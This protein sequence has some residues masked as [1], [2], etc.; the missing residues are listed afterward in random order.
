MGI[1][2]D[3]IE[4]IVDAARRAG[5]SAL[6]ETE[7]IELLSVLGIK[8]PPHFFV[9]APDDVRSSD[10]D[11]LA[12]ERVVVKVISGTILHKTELGGV[13]VTAKEQAAVRR[14]IGD[15]RDRLS[16][17]QLEGFTVHQFVA[18]DPSL[19][20]ELLLG[21]RWTEDFG[22][23]VVFGGGGIH[24]ELLARHFKPGRNIAVL[25]ALV[26]PSFGISAVLSRTAVA[27]LVSWRLRGREPR[28]PLQRL[29]EACQKVGE[30]AASFS[31]GA[32]TD[33]EINPL[34][35]ADGELTALDVLAKLAPAR[36]RAQRPP[37]PLEKI[38]N[39]LE[40]RSIAVVG[41]SGTNKNAGRV[42]LENSL[43]EGFDRDNLFVVKP[44]CGEIE[45]CRCFP[46]IR[47]LPGKIDLVVLAVGA[48][49]IPDLVGQIVAHEKAESVIVIP[50]GLEEKS[51]SGATVS[52]L[53]E[54]I[55]D[56][57]RLPWRGPVINGGNSLGIRSRPGRY[58]TM[59]I[60]KHKLGD[61]RHGDGSVAF[62]SQ[63]GAFAIAKGSTLSSVDLRYTISIGNQ[64]DLTIGDY[65]E[66]L[67]TDRAID[68]FAVYVEGFK[69]LDGVRFL[70]AA[71]KI[72]SS[73]R[74]V[75]LYA[76]GR[77]EAGARA[78]ASHTASVAGNYAVTRDLSLG[79]GVVVAETLADFEDLVMLFHAVR[80]RELRGLRL[81][82]VSNA[83]FE[84][85][86]VADNLGAFRLEPFSPRTVAAILDIF[87][88]AGVDRIVDV[89][90]PL[91]LTPMVND[92]GYE[93]V[94]RTVMDDDE[95]DVGLVGCVPLSPALNTLTPG[96]GHKEDLGSDDS[97]V[98]R[99]IRLNRE[100]QK[101]WIAVVDGG[102]L[103]SAMRQQ[104]TE[105]GVATF[106]TADRA[107]Q[108]LTIFY[109][110]SL[111]KPPGI[112]A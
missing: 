70:E 110:T 108:I 8:T 89:H 102:S 68:I 32:F 105:N 92:A 52:K 17:R 79:A 39:L 98:R 63:S 91:D 64:M 29:I 16:D 57:R 104:L 36:D 3:R 46:D 85:V 66:Y 38:R 14:A 31:P 49:Q 93:A 71:K 55:A 95:V 65:L 50:G 4:Q 44:E 109:E 81:G 26:P 58:D 13:V 10:L 22:P 80:G 12:G 53:S 86:A 106:R 7:G 77:S 43:R 9:R 1:A 2:R 42:I 34:V 21:F 23:V 76:A 48:A 18:F 107:L 72:T 84:C 61:R 103:Y 11:R 90:N 51:G 73:G 112:I 35:V 5:R 25:S 37:R 56:S 24:T 45:G 59:F 19:G 100:I 40:P 101:P 87:R 67:E 75:I 60:P 28:I 99:M 94:I 30:L 69:A 62:I 78:T 15:M 96:P 54:T 33:F 82:A 88:Q 20:G 74:T 97:I 41:V 27:Q 83:G 111:R 47:S 6:L